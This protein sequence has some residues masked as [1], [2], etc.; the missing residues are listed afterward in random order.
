MSCNNISNHIV[1]RGNQDIVW[2]LKRITTHEEP[3]IVSHR[4][5]QRAWY[6]VT[7]EYEIGE[8][9]TDSISIIIPDDPSYVICIQ[10]RKTCF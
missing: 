6:N 10:M 1:Q 9:I 4:N 8:T 5:Y 7:V 2:E 3:L